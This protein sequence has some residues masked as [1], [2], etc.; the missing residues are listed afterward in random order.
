MSSWLIGLVR[1]IEVVVGARDS[2]L[3]SVGGSLVVYEDDQ[4]LK[5]VLED[6]CAVQVAMKIR[7]WSLMGLQKL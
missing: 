2:V 3:K 5:G 1:W 4:M 6:R 7:L